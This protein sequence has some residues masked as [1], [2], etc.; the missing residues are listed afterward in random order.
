MSPVTLARCEIAEA[1]N[2]SRPRRNAPAPPVT[3]LQRALDLLSDG[4]ALSEINSLH[5]EISA[6]VTRVLALPVNQRSTLRF[7]KNN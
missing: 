7:W 1:P 5:M 4:I 2:S 6:Y 3:D